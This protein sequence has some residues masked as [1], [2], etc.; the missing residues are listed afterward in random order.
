M[1]EMK[2]F[3]K[4]LGAIGI[5]QAAGVAGSLFTAS[6]IPVWYATLEKPW[7]SPPNWIFGPVWIVLYTFMG[8]ALYL[9]VSK[10]L[11]RKEVKIATA[12]FLVHLIV[13]ASWSVLF[14]GLR[15]PLYGLI[16]IFLLLF[17][18][19]VTMISFWRISRGAAYL[20]IPYLLWV[21]FASALNF[22]IWQLN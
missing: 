7:F 16:D 18:I 19:V 10:G 1:R 12:V 6:A 5:C 13:N 9:V 17:M 8:I 3:L 22:A 15:S 11:E 20:L 2:E 4:L 14:F 21:L